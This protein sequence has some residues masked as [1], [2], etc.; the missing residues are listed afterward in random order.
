MNECLLFAIYILQGSYNL[1]KPRAMYFDGNTLETPLRCVITC[2]TPWKIFNLACVAHQFVIWFNVYTLV[3]VNILQY[4]CIENPWK[5]TFLQWIPTYF[6]DNCDPCKTA[7]GFFL[8]L[9][10][11]RI[12]IYGLSVILCRLVVR[13]S[14]ASSVPTDNL[15]GVYSKS[16]LDTVFCSP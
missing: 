7:G 11:P 1:L 8:L 12:L 4:F 3:W 2:Y 6:A 5:I 14:W 15:F 13:L 10:E 9:Y 16:K